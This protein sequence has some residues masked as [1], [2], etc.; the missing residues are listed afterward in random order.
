MSSNFSLDL[1][2][3]ECGFSCLISNALNYINQFSDIKPL[4]FSRKLLSLFFLMNFLIFKTYNTEFYLLIFCLQFLYL[5]ACVRLICIFFVLSFW[6]S[7]LYW[8]FLLVLIFWKYY[9]SGRIHDEDIK[10]LF[11]YFVGRNK[12][13]ILFTES[14][15][16]T[17]SELCWIF[18]LDIVSEVL[19]SLK[20]ISSFIFFFLFIFFGL[21][22]F[23]LR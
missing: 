11:L 21:I 12:R 23:L 17:V 2:R 7:S 18:L 1:L 16:K 20:M 14:I 5:Y 15:F 3:Q 6:I 4:Y 10:C 9:L 13:R 22:L 19:F 8:V